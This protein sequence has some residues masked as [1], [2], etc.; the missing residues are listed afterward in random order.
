MPIQVASAPVSWGVME[1]EGFDGQKSYGEVLDEMVQAGYTG[2]ELGP[3]GFL[4]TDPKQLKRELATRG[5]SLLGAFVPLPLAHVEQHEAAVLSAME[6]ARLLAQAGAPYMVL[7]DAMDAARMAVAGSV[8]EDRDGMGAQ[9]WEAAARLL[10]SLARAASALGLSP[11]FHHHCGTFIETPAEVD[12]LL[13]MTDPELLGLCL[14]T[15]HYF[16]GG[17]DPVECAR[18]YGKRIRHLHL[19]DVQPSVLETVR[20]KRIPY[21]DAIRASVFCEL[22]EGGVDLT[23]VI[24]QLNAAGFNGWAVF[25]Q[26]VDTSQPGCNPVESATRSRAYLRKV[27]GV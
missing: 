16:Y 5:L 2:T 11:V 19:K 21:L 8:D 13:A 1:V 15:G 12:R 18:V 10:T 3:Y 20:R 26:D 27:A 6:V 23:G 24:H 17:G 14:D 25:E 4:P 22:G 7:A 9:A